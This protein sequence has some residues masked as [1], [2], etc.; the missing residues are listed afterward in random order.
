[1]ILIKAWRS[2]DLMRIAD[3]YWTI[4][5]AQVRLPHGIDRAGVA[6]AARHVELVQEFRKALHAADPDDEKIVRLG[7]R[8]LHTRPGLLTANERSQIVR[9]KVRVGA[10]SRLQRAATSGDHQRVSIVYQHVLALSN[11]VEA[12]GAD[13]SSHRID[14]AAAPLPRTLP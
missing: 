8:L 9:T 5:Q 14:P 6:E 2:G 13:G 7:T 12:T 11:D 4:T 3:A 10:R 1:M